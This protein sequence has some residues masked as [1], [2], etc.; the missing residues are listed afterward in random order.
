MYSRYDSFHLSGQSQITTWQ[1]EGRD[2]AACGRFPQAATH[3]LF[4]PVT[5]LNLITS[6]RK[7]MYNGG[8]VFSLQ[9]G[10]VFLI[11]AGTLISSEILRTSEPFSSINIILPTHL[12]PQKKRT[13]ANT[14]SAGMLDLP[15]T[16]DWHS[17]SGQLM[18]DF[19]SSSPVSEPQELL[20]KIAHL[21]SAHPYV[22]EMLGNTAAHDWPVVMENL[23][24]GIPETRSLEQLAQLGHMSVATLKRRF[25]D[26]YDKSPMQWVWEMRLQRAA[27]LLRTAAVPINEIA[28]STGFSDLSHFYHQFKK[29]FRMTP[30][31]WRE[32]I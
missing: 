2:W 17:L 28:Y 1:H 27:L 5:I 23:G 29:Y 18:K 11:P 26:I 32:A 16:A 12:F 7:R 31:Q 21:M 15:V 20:E 25:K 3:E 6:G 9:Q 22:T 10:D 8:R 13:S 19:N 30:L 4:T 14:I 24:M